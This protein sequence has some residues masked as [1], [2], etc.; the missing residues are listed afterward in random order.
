VDETDCDGG[1]V[2]LLDCDK[3]KQLSNG[4][5]ISVS[6]HLANSEDTAA[7]PLYRVDS[8]K[9]VANSNDTGQAAGSE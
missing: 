6:G 1:S 3:L 7:S 8:L 9:R 5:Y 4:Q 2:T